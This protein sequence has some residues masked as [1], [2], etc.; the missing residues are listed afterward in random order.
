MNFYAERL[1]RPNKVEWVLYPTPGLTTFATAPESPGRGIFAQDGRCFAIIG[2]A[3]YEIF[4]DGTRTNRGTVA[5][6][7]YPATL[8]TNGD[9]GG[10]LF[11]TSGDRGYVFD[12]TTHV[13]TQVV[14]DV[15]MGGMLSNYFVALD[16]TTST[17]KVSNLL[18]GLV[19]DATIFAQRST[20]SD[21]WRSLMV[22]GVYLVLLGEQT[23][24]VYYSTGV[25]NDP[26]APV[27]GV[28]FPFGIVAPFSLQK[29][30]S[31]LCWLAQ[32]EAGA[33][34]IV[35]AQGLNPVRISTHALEYALS[36]YSRVD[37]AVA[38]SY[39]DQGHEFYELNFPQ[40]RATWVYDNSTG[41]WHERGH[42][43]STTAVYTAWAPQYHAYAFGQHLVLDFQTGTIYRMAV[44]LYRDADGD[45]IRRER[46]PPHLFQEDRRM[47]IDRLQLYCDVGLGLVSGQGSTPQVSVQ[48]SA[49]G[50]HTWGSERWRSAGVLGDYTQRVEWHRCGSGRDVAHR[51]V[52]TD[53]IAWRLL[54]C[55]VDARVA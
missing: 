34:L 13:L 16:N 18:N 54:D 12:L 30:G 37:D 5:T 40:A 52:V 24:D 7:Q 45:V 6:D 20:Q 36:Q 3:L 8:T 27:P 23:G 19:W 29:V 32:N 42:W 15:T 22:Y 1:E 51:F 14:L 41:L 25:A 47:V 21:P 39:Q 55:Y 49:D 31:A 43:N 46:I 48:Q 38:F 17:L 50:G 28:T 4:A 2:T 53:P 9:G 26:F 11:I 35:Q 44:D 10:Q 33:A